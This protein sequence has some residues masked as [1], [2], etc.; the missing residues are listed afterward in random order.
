M[1]LA[2]GIKATAFTPSNSKMQTDL[3]AQVNG[4]APAH[5]IP[6][7]TRKTVAGNLEGKQLLSLK[8][9]PSK[10]NTMA[11]MGGKHLS[12]TPFIHG[13]KHVC[14][15]NYRLRVPPASG[16]KK[17]SAFKEAA[18]FLSPSQ[19]TFCVEGNNPDAEH[20]HG[21]DCI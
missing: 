1:L 13:K 19:A 12:H 16:Q 3:F 18:S 11:E 6:A 9:E 14:A 4:V 21:K 5:A 10:E 20:C 8:L 15:N 17:V 2:V 7:V